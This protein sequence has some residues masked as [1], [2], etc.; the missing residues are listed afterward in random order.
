[1]CTLTLVPTARANGINL[2]IAFNR[3]EKR[4]RPKALPPVLTATP[5]TMACYPL[6]FPGGGT[7]MAATS[8]GMVFALLN[9]NSASARPEFFLQKKS[10]G[11]IILKFFGAQSQAAVLAIMQSLSVH[12]FS[13]FRVLA[14]D[15]EQWQ[16]WIFN[17]A[18]VTFERGTH[19]VGKTVIRTSSS[20]AQ[21]DDYVQKPRMELWNELF[22][23]NEISLQNQEHFHRFQWGHDKISSIFMERP[24]ARTVSH[25]VV[26]LF[27]H[28]LIMRYLGDPDAFRQHGYAAVSHLTTLPVGKVTPEGLVHSEGLQFWS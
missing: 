1:M 16:E 22:Q 23:N 14:S 15:L 9:V 4:I 12:D 19:A 10:R 5:H 25:T 11:E 3:D 2:R 28:S 8:A 21:G 26:D 27:P 24:D 6:D 13:P 18:E 17:G 7:W 20:Y